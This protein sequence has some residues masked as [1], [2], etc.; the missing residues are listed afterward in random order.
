MV[1]P[2][3]LRTSSSAWLARVLPPRRVDVR[4]EAAVVRRRARPRVGRLVE[5]AAR[6][7]EPRGRPGRRRSPAS[8][9][10]AA[11]RRETSP[12]SSCS[13]PS[14]SLIVLSTNSAKR[15]LRCSDSDSIANDTTVLPK[16]PRTRSVA[17]PFAPNRARVIAR[18]SG[19]CGDLRSPEEPFRDGPTAPALPCARE[20]SSILKPGRA[21]EPLAK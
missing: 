15:F 9:E 3:C 7:L 21:R 12:R 8:A 10:R 14:I 6:A 5:P 16:E 19:G 4:A 1:T 20:D 13:R 18:G 17:R 11:S 2:G